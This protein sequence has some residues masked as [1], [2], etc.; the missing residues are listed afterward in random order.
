MRTSTLFLYPHLPGV[1]S[2]FQFHFVHSSFFWNSILELASASSRWYQDK[3]INR[4]PTGRDWNSDCVTT[5][6]HIE[7]NIHITILLSQ[8]SLLFPISVAPPT[9]ISLSGPHLHHRHD[10]DLIIRRL[11]RILYWRP[12]LINKRE[13]AS[14]I[15]IWAWQQCG[16]R[17]SCPASLPLPCLA[18]SH[19]AHPPPARL[20]A[21][22]TTT[23]NKFY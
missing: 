7:R 14:W 15:H 19:I 6:N 9:F 1:F 3:W 10:N 5:C 12:V 22:C 11:K 2:I 13:H 20:S 4:R 18:R 16:A 17:S 8:W 21:S 23:P